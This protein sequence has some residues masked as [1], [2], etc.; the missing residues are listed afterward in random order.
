MIQATTLKRKRQGG[1]LTDGDDLA[2]LELVE[3][4]DF[5]GGVEADHEDPHLLLGEEPAEELPEH[6]PHL[7][8]SA[9]A[10]LSFTTGTIVNRSLIHSSI[11]S[12]TQIY[13][14][15]RHKPYPHDGLRATPV[16]PGAMTA[17]RI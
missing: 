13:P 1:R 12:P 17:P 3:D 5:T 11:H 2:E 14:P 10:P 15:L 6:E 4:G 7:P 16:R 8:S 9:A